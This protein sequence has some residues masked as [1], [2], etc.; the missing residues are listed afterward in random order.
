MSR[1]PL[2]ASLQVVLLSRSLLAAAA[3]LGASPCR[4][5]RRR[6]T[7]AHPRLA[8]GARVRRPRSS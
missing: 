5:R 7:A 3:L 1:M 2:P 6:R 4:R 8:L